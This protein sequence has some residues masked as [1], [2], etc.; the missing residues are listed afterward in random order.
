MELENRE[1]IDPMCSK[2]KR[3]VINDFYVHF[4]FLSI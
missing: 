2:K 3:F 1:Y 4:F